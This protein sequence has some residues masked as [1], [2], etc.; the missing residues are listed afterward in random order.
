MEGILPDE[1]QPGMP[2][3]KSLIERAN[4]DI[5]QGTRTL[6]LQAGLPAC[7]ST[8]AAPCYCMLDNISDKKE[9]V[10]AWELTYGEDF[11]GK[12]LPF[13]CLVSYIP[14][15]TKGLSG[16]VAKWD[17]SA[18]EGIF[19]GYKLRP[20]YKW[21][22]IYLVWDLRDFFGVSLQRDSGYQNIGFH[23]PH[24]S[25]RSELYDGKLTFPLK[26][27]YDRANATTEGVD[28]EGAGGRSVTGASGSTIPADF[29]STEERD[30]GPVEPV[31]TE[32]VGPDSL[33]IA[34]DPSYGHYKIDK[35]GRRYPVDETGT[36]KFQFSGG[37]ATSRPEGVSGA[38]RSQL[39]SKE[40]AHVHDPTTFGHLPRSADDVAESPD[41][42]AEHPAPGGGRTAT[43]GDMEP[44][45]SD[46]GRS[47]TVPD[48][49][50]E[51]DAG[52][53]SADATEPSMPAVYIPYPE[54]EEPWSMWEQ[55]L[56]CGSY[57]L[58]G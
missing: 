46:C 9:S 26:E 27:R 50:P 39:T 56:A 18:R 7:F 35:R 41:L 55:S 10:S 33:G 24:Q 37:R 19:A 15:Q 53:L 44:G 54:G 52:E 29:V 22:G 25:S 57:E 23:D 47:A 36:R 32:A 1:S 43:A 58:E 11:P 40:K 34:F 28:P 45:G 12:R 42:P 31:R 8:F 49:P 30:E 51:P 4:Q 5:L 3:T 6:L 14:S 20:G 16:S 2:Q 21:S 13:G 38:L 48:I 17:P